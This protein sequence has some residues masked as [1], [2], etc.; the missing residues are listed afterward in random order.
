[1]PILKTIERVHGILLKDSRLKILKM[2]EMVDISNEKT[3]YNVVVAFVLLK[4]EWSLNRWL[5]KII[6]LCFLKKQE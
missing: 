2:A 6:Y 4:V 3:V 1:M 5:I